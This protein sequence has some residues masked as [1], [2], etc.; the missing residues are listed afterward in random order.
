MN[1]PVFRFAPSPNGLLH[2][3]HAY[4]ALLNLRM[5]RRAGA[6]LLLR[7]EDI[8]TVRCTP[9]NEAMMLKDLEWLGFE[10]DAPP[11]RQSEHFDEYRAA[12][13][14]LLDAGLAYPA[15]MSRAEIRRAVEA[16]TASGRSWPCDPDGAPHY[17]GRERDLDL[18][19]R[20][21][22]VAG[23]GDYTLRLDAAA[24]AAHIGR[25]L[26][27]TEEGC[28]PD[29]QSGRIRADLAPW[30]DPILGRR[31][32]PA[33]YH[34]ACVIDDAAQGVSDV[35]RGRDLFFAT[36]IHRALQELFGLPEPAYF[37]HDLI[38]D[39][40]GRK[41]SKSR[42]STALRHLRAAGLTATDIARMVGLADEPVR[43]A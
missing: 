15:L 12:L 30:G 5:A 39:E 37:H 36:A 19:R 22:I 33:S 18:A 31:D 2:L 9:E 27:W 21:Q 6:T 40:D 4:S 42:S 11:R 41:L 16:A 38:L 24:A 25:A 32:V 10:W 13:D 26:H 43:C 28:G 35:V 3:G 7:I 1:K 29:G 34:L 20:R 14:E 23:S 17:P 8:D